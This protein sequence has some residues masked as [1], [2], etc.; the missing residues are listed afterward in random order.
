MKGRLFGNRYEIVEYLG[1]GGMAQ[2]YKSWDRLL[3]RAVTIK[4]LREGLTNDEEFVRRFRR[5]A[6]AIA[7]L[8]HPNIV[9]VYDV[10]REGETDYIVMEY[11]DGPTLK[12]V[13]RRRGPLPPVEAVNLARQICDALEHAHENKIIHR[14]IKPHNILLTNSGRVKV[15]DFGIAR[16]TTQNTMTMD[17]TIVGSV[18]YLSPEQARGLPVDEK[19]DIYSLGVVLYELLTGRVPFQGETPIAV[20]LQQIQEQ[21][22]ALSEIQ[23]EVPQALEEIVLRALEKSAERRYNNARALREDLE[24]V[25]TGTIVGRLPLDD[26]SPTMRLDLPIPL[27]KDRVSESNKTPQTEQKAKKVQ[28]E[29][30]SPVNWKVLLS[31]LLLL[32]L[33]AF[34]SSFAWQRYMNVPE[35]MLPRVVGMHYRE[36]I[37]AIQKEGLQVQVEAV[38]HREVARDLVISQDPE[39]NRMVKQTREVRLTVSQGPKLHPVPPV[40]GMTEREAI[41]RLQEA[42][43]AYEITEEYSERGA[44]GTVLSQRPAANTEQPAGTVIELRISKGPQR[45]GLMPALIGLSAEEAKTLLKPLEVQIEQQEEKSDRHDAGTVLSQDPSA[46]SRVDKG[47]TVRITISTMAEVQIQEQEQKKVTPITLLIPEESSEAPVRI[48]LI[49]GEQTKEVYAGTHKGGD[50]V[51][52]QVEYTGQATIQGFINGEKVLERKV[53]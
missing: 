49:Q 45:Q 39:G 24:H 3:E 36:A 48:L 6:Q 50:T 33:I 31:S 15:T 13:I 35:V 21:P 43:F 12:E 29:S 32:A 1:G 37:E 41:L 18:H 17:R 44:V 51:S 46:N 25:F 19:S 47:A 9:N 14:D 38:H 2:V 30:S 20:A 28:E 52:Q 11:I 26:D 5:E 34:A 7:S 8:S 22:Q 27:E 42:D 16:S 4:F 53:E 23:E 10:G 40:T